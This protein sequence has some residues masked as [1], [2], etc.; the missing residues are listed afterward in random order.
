MSKG[1][2]YSKMNQMPASVLKEVKAELV[3]EFYND[4]TDYID[5]PELTMKQKIILW[6][7][8]FI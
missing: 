7:M 8:G 5:Y 2:I 1:I 4:L 6:L 3:D